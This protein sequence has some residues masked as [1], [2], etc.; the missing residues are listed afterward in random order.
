[1][2]ITRRQLALTAA[3]AAAAIPALAQQTAPTA[4]PDWDKKARD[5]HAASSQ[6]IQKIDL[7][8]LLEPAFVFKA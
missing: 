8:Q 2:K 6:A 7:P 5:D 4:S 1:M 3:G